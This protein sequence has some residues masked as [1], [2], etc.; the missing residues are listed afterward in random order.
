MLYMN[1][2]NKYCLK[3]KFSGDLI[4]RLG[5]SL[6]EKIVNEIFFPALSCLNLT[7]TTKQ[8]VF[9]YFPKSSNWLFEEIF[10]TEV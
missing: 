10:K 1:Q 2:I 7:K 9:I 8:Y 4:L 6:E 5:Y 3:M